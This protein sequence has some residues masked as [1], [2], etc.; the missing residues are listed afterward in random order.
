M[1][2]PNQPTQIDPRAGIL[3]RIENDFVYHPPHG[4]QIERYAAIRAQ[5]LKSARFIANNTPPSREQSLALTSLEEAM[6]WANA[7]IA[8]NE[9][10]P[11]TFK[12]SV[13]S[14]TAGYDDHGTE[15]Q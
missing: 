2:D 6:F 11:I 1:N 13:V 9:K 14:G 15:K 10:T 4:D 7:A 3:A 12:T 5:I 8:R